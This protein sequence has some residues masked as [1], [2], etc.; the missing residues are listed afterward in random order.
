MLCSH[1]V[2]IV[3]EH[4]PINP[5]TLYT[6]KHCPF[7]EN[8]QLIRASTLKQRIEDAG[9]VD[10]SVSYRVFFPDFLKPLRA[11]EKW[12]A[13]L[14]LGAQYYVTGGKAPQIASKNRTRH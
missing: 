14:P 3:F 1:G 6:V 13:W 8:A 11:I 9:L 10:L 7:D 4:N 12:M 5:L 2:V